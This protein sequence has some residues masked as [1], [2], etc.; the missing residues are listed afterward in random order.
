MLSPPGARPLTPGAARN[1]GLAACGG[2]WVLFVDADMEVNAA[3]VDAR[4][5]RS[6][7]RTPRLAGIWGRLEEW[8]VDAAGERPGARD[9]YQVGERGPR[10]RATSRTLALYRRAALDAARAATIRG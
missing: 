4:A 1:L 9:M 7:A 5:R 8:F 2:A 6:T 10:H 3:W